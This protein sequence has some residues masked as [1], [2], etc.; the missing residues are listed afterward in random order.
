MN[1]H[2]SKNEGNYEVERTKCIFHSVPKRMTQYSPCFSGVLITAC[3]LMQS[4]K[5]SSFK[6]LLAATPSRNTPAY[7]KAAGQMLRPDCPTVY[8]G[9]LLPWMVYF[10]Q[11]LPWNGQKQ[12]ISSPGRRSNA[13]GAKKS[14]RQWKLIKNKKIVT[15]TLFSVQQQ[16]W[17]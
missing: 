16:C 13:R 14:W 4:I 3:L 2:S 8:F 9:Q 1:N 5:G 10:G 7:T 11:L 6:N 15:D 12:S 17:S